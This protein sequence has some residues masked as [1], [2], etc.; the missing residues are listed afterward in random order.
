MQYISSILNV[1]P[2]ENAYFKSLLQHILNNTSDV[3]LDC[4]H[5]EL[6]VIT[7]MYGFKW[8]ENGNK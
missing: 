4:V 5:L 8:N 6:S 2:F 7:N 1:I 3:N